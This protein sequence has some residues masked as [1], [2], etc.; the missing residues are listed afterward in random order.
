MT[1]RS[2]VLFPGAH[3]DSPLR[4]QISSEFTSPAALKAECASFH[5]KLLP[6]LLIIAFLMIPAHL[7]GQTWAGVIDPSRAIDWRNNAGVKFAIPSGSWAACVTSAC[8]IVTAAGSSANIAQINAAIASAPANSYVAL[9]P[10]TYS[11]SSCL[12]WVGHSHVVLR[13]SGPLKTIVKFTGGCGGYSGST[14]IRLMASSNIFDQSATTQPGA[15]NSLTITGTAGTASGGPTGPGLYPQGATQITVSNVGSDSPTVGTV[16]IIDQADDTSTAAGWLVCQQNTTTPNC[17]ANGNNAGRLVGGVLHEQIQAVVITNISGSTYTISPGLY[18]NNMRSSQ[19]PGAWWNFSSALCVQCGIENITLDHT[20]TGTLS[21][22]V[23]AITID[24]CYQCW[25]KNIRNIYGGGRNHIYLAQSA[26]GVIRD[27]YFFGSVGRSSGGGYGIDP[28]ESSDWLIE[29][30]IFDEVPAPVVGENYSG[31]VFGYNFSWNNNPGGGLI[32]TYPSHDP[33]SMMVLLEGN[34]LNAISQDTQHGASPTFTYFRNDIPGQQPVPVDV[35]T[36]SF[37]NQTPFEL[38]AFQHAENIIGNTLGIITCSGGTFNGRPADKDSQCVGGSATGRSWQ[39]G[40]ETSPTAG[41][42]PCY[43]TIYTLGWVANCLSV[44]GSFVADPGVEASLMRWGNYDT[45]TASVQWNAAE[46]PT[47]LFSFISGN[48]VPSS[49]TLPPSFY[50]NSKPSWWQGGSFTAP[51]FPPIGPDV[52]G[53]NLAG[54]GGHAYE[55]LARL[56][57]ENAPQ[58]STNYPSTNVIA[59]DA[60]SCYGSALSMAPAPPTGLSASVK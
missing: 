37:Q 12:D 14:D 40:Y 7:F 42:T 19:S 47:S 60:N 2:K 8:N 25:L 33:G 3:N 17:S 36:G 46:V 27:S 57:Y 44:Y 28:V 29:N 23:S 20:A 39:T 45:V 52:T 50:Y 24:N 43:Q 21:G 5:L 11:L 51:P 15:S 18:A 59:F 53:G 26:A 35:N 56:C 22:S 30:N 54:L 34:Y 10:G 31:F 49:H 38:Q 16:L 48:P 4:A 13:G 9:Q 32:E 1:R 41:A 58:D 55:N 6:L